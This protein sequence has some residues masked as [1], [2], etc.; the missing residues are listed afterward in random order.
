[1]PQLNKNIENIFPASLSSV[2]N[3]CEVLSY[4]PDLCL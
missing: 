2:Y 4:I 1:M 3:N